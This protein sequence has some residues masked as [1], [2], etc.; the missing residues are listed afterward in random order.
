[1]A[2]KLTHKR[3]NIAIICCS[4]ENEL[5]IAEGILDRLVHITSC[6]VVKHN[7]RATLFLQLVGKNMR[8]LFCVS[9]NG[10]V[11]DNNSFAFDRIGRPL[12]IKVDVVTEIFVKNRSVKCANCRNIKSF[13]LF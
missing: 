13:N 8:R 12:L 1:M 6:K 11:C 9:V 2:N 5:S 4:S 7:L 10:S 3:E